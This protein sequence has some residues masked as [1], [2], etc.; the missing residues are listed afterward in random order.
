[1]TPC[2]EFVMHPFLIMP[3]WCQAT[4]PLSFGGL[5]LH[6]ASCVSPAVFIGSCLSSQ[7]LCTQLLSYFY[8]SVPSF[9]PIP[10]REL[11]FVYLSFLT[12]GPLPVVD[13]PS[14]VQHNFQHSMDLHRYSSLLIVF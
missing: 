12:G 2:Y 5:G 1:M 11:A 6:E 13:N 8:G 14:K 7:S 4:L 10:G 9:P 3:A